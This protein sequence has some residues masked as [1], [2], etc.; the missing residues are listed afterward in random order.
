MA[1][2]RI[3]TMIWMPPMAIEALA[4]VTRPGCAP[5]TREMRHAFFIAGT[6]GNG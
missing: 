3:E 5:Y 4:D 6:G 1:L 2:R